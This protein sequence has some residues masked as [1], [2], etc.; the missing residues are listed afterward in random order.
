M[1]QHPFQSIPDVGVNDLSIWVKV[2]GKQGCS[3]EERSESE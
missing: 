1:N 3:R 2:I